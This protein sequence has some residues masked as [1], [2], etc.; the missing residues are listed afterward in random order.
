M[1]DGVSDGWQPVK[2]VPTTIVPNR[3]LEA[4]RKVA[5]AAKEYR[6]SQRVQM[7]NTAKY[8]EPL[9]E[10][11]RQAKMVLDAALAAWEKVRDEA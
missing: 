3:E 8:D 5:E 7:L 2:L 10:R 1:S 4:L 11:Q 9:Y 6:D